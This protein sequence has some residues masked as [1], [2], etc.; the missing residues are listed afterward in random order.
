MLKEFSCGAVIYKIQNNSPVFLLVMSKRNGRWCFPKGHIENGENEIDTTKREIFEETGIKKLKFIE[1]FRQEDIYIINSA[2]SS[3]R[4]EKVE[5]H[6]IYFLALA[7]EN[8]MDFDRNEISKLKWF[9]IIQA[10]NLLFFARQ[11]KII[12]MAYRL[13]IGGQDE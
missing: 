7:L 10:Q 12:N 13:I 4:C 9:N 2:L 5:K 3:N 6:S 11:K 1:N 8:S